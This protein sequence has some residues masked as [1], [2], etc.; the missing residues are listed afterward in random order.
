MT[1]L[2]ELKMGKQLY[3]VFANGMDEL[4][5]E[6]REA[7]AKELAKKGFPEGD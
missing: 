6:E 7:F 1:Q 4:T 2:K 5:S 3:K